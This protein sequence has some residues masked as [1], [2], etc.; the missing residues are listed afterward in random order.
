MLSAIRDYTTAL[1]RL[2]GISE[3]LKCESSV[4]VW[5]S[6]QAPRL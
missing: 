3:K 5:G 4:K 2:K 6:K 1:D